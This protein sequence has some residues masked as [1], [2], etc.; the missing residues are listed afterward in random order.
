MPLVIAAG[1]LININ[2]NQ[3][4][5]LEVSSTYPEESS[6]YPQRNNH[7]KQQSEPHR[8]RCVGRKVVQDLAYAKFDKTGR[9]LT[10][11]DLIKHG[12]TPKQAKS[13][14]HYHKNKGNLYANSPITIPQQY[15]CSKE[16]AI[17]AATYS[18]RNIHPDPIGGTTATN[19]LATATPIAIAKSSTASISSGGD[20]AAAT[21]AA[22]VATAVGSSSAADVV[23]V[24]NDD[25]ATSVADAIDKILDCTNDLPIAMH[26]I[27]LQ[28]T[29]VNPTEAY[30]E[31]LNLRNNP[32]CYFTTHANKEKRLEFYID[33]YL[34]QCSVYPNGKVV[35]CINSSSRPLPIS[36]NN[37]DKT[38][39]DFTSFVA[40]IRAFLV[41]NLRDFHSKIV[42]P[43]H[44]P[45]WCLVHAD[46]NTDIPTKDINFRGCIQ[47]NDFANNVVLKIYKK[48]LGP[49]GKRYIRFEEGVHTFKNAP[50]NNSIGETIVT[51]AKEA[52][53]NIRRQFG[54]GQE[55][56]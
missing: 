55:L 24:D 15:F 9:G 28:T 41:Q 5:D 30:E 38:T 16:D 10:Y 53:Q 18:N 39:S 36:P 8:R 22:A 45:S 3:N 56:N 27:R 49:Q 20:I 29:L 48:R 47:V 40:Q 11:K 6:T 14:L 54:G 31:R 43:I 26:N 25:D 50:I 17:E 51:A 21:A 34:V 2:Q 46:F 33:G 23:A 35:I 12:K 13:I 44:D 19:L 42:P 1:D 32:Y 4:N 7:L 52:Q 37:R